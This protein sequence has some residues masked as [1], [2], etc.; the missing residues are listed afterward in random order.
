LLP[1]PPLGFA[2]ANPNAAQKT[3]WL[4]HFH[5]RGNNGRQL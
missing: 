2:K 3:P 5:P 1:P 4:A